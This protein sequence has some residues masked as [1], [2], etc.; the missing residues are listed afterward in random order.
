MLA[1]FASISVV[2]YAFSLIMGWLLI[3]GDFGLLAFAQTLLL[4]AGLALNSGFSWSLA[5]ALARHDTSRRAA[6]IRGAMAANA[7]LA[8]GISGAIVGLFALGPLR[9][10][11]ETATVTA[12]VALTVPLLSY[13]SIVRA[14]A[15]GVER[16][17]VMAFNQAVE[18]IAKAAAGLLLVEAGFGA[19]GAVAGFLIGALVAALCGLWVLRLLDGRLWGAVELPHL[20]AAGGMFGALLGLALL[21]NLDVVAVKLFAGANRAVTGQYQAATILANTP[22][23]LVAAMMP[24]L[25]TRLTRTAEVA[26]TRATVV[27]AL[28]LT[29]LFLLPIEFALVAAP[30]LALGRLFP[31]TYV[32]AAPLL[33][34]LAL[35]NCAVILTVILSTTFQAIGRAVIPARAL[36]ATTTVE[37]LFLRLLVPTWHAAGAATLF[38]V[39]ATTTL[40]ALGFV[41]AR[42][43]GFDAAQH[44]ANWLLRYLGVLSVATALGAVAR[45]MGAG[46][47][48]AVG[49][50]GLCFASGVVLLRLLPLPELALRSPAPCGLDPAAVNG[51]E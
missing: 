48:P 37:A 40:V 2:N 38:C 41:Y 18:V 47:V 8:L 10:G 14:A 21:L 49:G 31:H 9:A 4:I 43:L 28:R 46:V 23:Y 32:V 24:I 45:A 26:E 30:D 16:F 50:A 20:R 17:G 6:L 5:A 1:S 15:Q 42:D 19:A 44:S 11:L 3:P 7:L 27:E 22:Y 36:L 29:L 12:L 51:D 39:A 25:F 35:G 33:R 13:S 34:L